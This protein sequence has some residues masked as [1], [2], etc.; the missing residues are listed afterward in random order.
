M[1]S[2]TGAPDDTARPPSP[3]T[4]P[5]SATRLAPSAPSMPIARRIPSAREDNV[6][7]ADLHHR[8]RGA[9]RPRPVAD[10]PGLRAGTM[11]LADGRLSYTRRRRRRVVFDAPRGRV[12]QLRPLL[13]GN[14]LP[15]LARVAPGTA[16]SSTTPCYPPSTGRA[17]SRTSPRAVVQIRQGLAKTARS[18]DD[19][20]PLARRASCPRSRRLPPREVD[21]RSAPV[22]ASR[23]LWTARAS[24]LAATLLLVSAS[25]RSWSHVVAG[26]RRA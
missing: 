24:V 19:G 16:S 17:P 25:P 4:A 23:F 9:G 8:D 6:S 22:A 10:H 18:R 11:R 13:D 14:G 21:V 20:R 2:P 12:P 3:R 7:H 5:D 1:S 26:R 15:P